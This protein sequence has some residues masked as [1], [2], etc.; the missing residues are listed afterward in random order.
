MKK[1]F[2]AAA[3]LILLSGAAMANT[4]D[5]SPKSKKA[6]YKALQNFPYD[7]QQADNVNWNM[8]GDYSEASFTLNGVA[9]KAFYD[10]DGNLAGTSQTMQYNDLPA[11]ARK[12]IDKYYKEYSIQKII[13]YQDNEENENDLYPL[14]PEESSI[15]YFVSMTKNG[16]TEEI[17]LQVTPNGQTSFFENMPGK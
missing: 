2:L 6:S 12:S 4:N 17:I 3:A 9:M 13:L 5:H 1:I 8:V 16:S 14:I 10:W 15:N 11:P 7:F